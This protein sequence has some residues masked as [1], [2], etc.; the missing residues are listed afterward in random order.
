MSL[1]ILSIDGGGTRGIIPATILDRIH[2]EYGRSPVDMFDLFAGTS[3]GGIICIGLAAGLPPSALVDLY[4][5]KSE[6][7]FSETFLDRLTN[8]DEHLQANYKNTKFK[9]I[10]KDLFGEKTLGDV[11]DD[12][13]F[14]GKGKHLMVCS[15]D[16]APDKSSDRNK[17]YRP[18]IFNSSF[19]KCRNIKLADLALMTSAGPTYFPIYNQQYIDGG[20][21][22]NNP[23]M[24]ALT[25]AINEHDDGEGYLYPD[26]KSKGLHLKFADLQLF[27][28]S[29]GTGNMNRIE[30]EKIRTGNWGNI[31]WIKYLPDLITETNMQST[32]YYVKQVLNDDQMYRVELFFDDENA[33]AILRSKPIGLDAKDKPTLQGMQQFAIATYTKEK[34]AIAKFLKL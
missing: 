5:N 16:L 32:I 11:H 12:P 18:V 8:L 1:K 28:L 15:F 17:N 33:P 14:G 2:K 34:N 24:A 23:S 19:I 9:K 6:K 27:S 25:F 22:L 31:Q 10:V 4:L 26:G 20:V 3:T 21:A 7:I 30:K 13:N 29:T